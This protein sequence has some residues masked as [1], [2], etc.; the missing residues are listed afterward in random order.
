MFG[1]CSTD[2]DGTHMRRRR[3]SV[4]IL[5][6]LVAFACCAFGVHSAVS[7][8]GREARSWELLTAAGEKAFARGDLA[9]ARE[10][11]GEAL[12]AA[13]SHGGQDPR[14]ARSLHN[15]A[16]LN[17]KEGN[18]GRAE[19]LF[20]KAIILKE[21][22][23]GAGHGEVAWSLV[24]A[25]GAYGDQGKFTEA[26]TA[27]KRAIHIYRRIHGYLHPSVAGATYDLGIVYVKRRD[28]I[29]A[30]TALLKSL[31][32]WKNT[33]G[34]GHEEFKRASSAYR[35]YFKD[36]PKL[37]GDEEITI[38]FSEVN[39]RLDAVEAV[40]GLRISRAIAIHG[41][42]INVLVPRGVVTK[43]ELLKAIAEYKKH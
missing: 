41:D 34:A 4:P 29:R 18:N 12:D 28:Y 35:H 38:R 43:K 16:F 39:N 5:T 30:K 14:V 23:Y 19:M 26:E 40:A 20:E 2:S 13:H 11:F 22:I 42:T 36:E 15:L 10:L 3:L 37:G 6:L 25:A 17:H 9:E 21:A 27:L 33:Y 24:S 8:D 7:N 1:R 32:R 31:S